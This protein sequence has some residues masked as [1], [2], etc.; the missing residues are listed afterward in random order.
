M[1]PEAPYSHIP[2]T[3]RFYLVSQRHSECIDFFNY[4]RE[5]KVV[6]L[7]ELLEQRS[8][9]LDEAEQRELIEWLDIVIKTENDDQVRE[10]AKTTQ[11]NYSF[12][13]MKKLD[14]K[15]EGIGLYAD[16]DSSN[17]IRKKPKLENPEHYK[18]GRE[19]LG[20]LKQ[21]Y[22]LN[23]LSYKEFLGPQNEYKLVEQV[24]GTTIVDLE[25]ID[26]GVADK[27][28]DQF[29][30]I[31]KY[32]A[33]RVASKTPFLRDVA[34]SYQFMYGHTKT[35]PEDKVWLHDLDYYIN[36]SFSDKTRQ[37]GSLSGE[38]YQFLRSNV[39]FPKVA[40]ELKRFVE[41]F[42]K[43]EIGKQNDVYCK[44]ILERAQRLG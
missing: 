13:P 5:R 1:N 41:D 25:E 11:R 17:W 42:S 28:D 43:T 20:A 36:N 39:K 15:W 44:A 29:S 31:I 4:D 37:I 22:G 2:D 27:I 3:D 40:A 26:Q 6:V 33:D 7:K 9:V 10:L 35:D 38:L 21:Q 14:E 18:I 30:K 34:S 23:V 19:E 16:P 12:E 8:K 24:E 32:I